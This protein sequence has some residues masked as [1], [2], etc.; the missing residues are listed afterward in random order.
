[1]AR[2]NMAKDTL[3]WLLEPSDIGVRYLAL[4]D[5]LKNNSKELLEVK[6]AA[7][8]DGPI[9]AVLAKMQPE[10]YWEV[11]K[12]HGMGEKLP[13]RVMATCWAALQLE[14]YYRYLP[15]F[16]IN[17]MDRHVGHAKEDLEQ[18]GVGDGIIIE[19]N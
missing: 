8:R 11:K 7:H 15:T 4:R 12:G 16:D 3:D 13:G 2:D 10:G 6:K 19:I 5:L 1:M 18:A 9:A 14:V 17:K